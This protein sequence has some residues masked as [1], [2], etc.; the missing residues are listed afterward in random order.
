M[1]ISENLITLFFRLRCG[2]GGGGGETVDDGIC[3]TQQLLQQGN[4]L[5]F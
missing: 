5:L 1:F 4:L 2:G 3:N